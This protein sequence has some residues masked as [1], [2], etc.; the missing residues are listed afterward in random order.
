MK[1]FLLLFLFLLA[2]S[3]PVF[4][5]QHWPSPTGN[6]NDFA[7]V[8]PTNQAQ[9]LEN[10]LAAIRQKTGVQIAVVTFPSVE[11][12]DVAG[13]AVDL[14][15][16]WGIGQK[17]KDNGLLILLS[18]QDRKDWIEVGYGLEATVTDGDTG[19]IR[20]NSME[21]SFKKGNFG[22]GLTNGVLQLAR[23]I[24]YDAGNNPVPPQ[25]Q[26]EQGGGGLGFL[27]KFVIFIII[28]ILLSVINRRGR[29][30]FW[31]GGFY[32]G[33]GWGGGGFGGGGGG[34]GGFGGGSSGG[35]GSGGSW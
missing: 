27:G 2:S 3:Y 16:V 15:H 28:F 10:L 5:A 35:G 11:G 23:L 12:G 1:K 14:F 24:G 29:G 20:R 13:A 7:H 32:G 22:E 30:G 19:T 8:V 25:I 6:F 31:G 21:P 34:F 17:E 9:A 4:A 33:G 18:I 26:Y